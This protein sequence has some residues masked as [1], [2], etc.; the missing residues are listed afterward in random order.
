MKKI[1]L[2]FLVF[3]LSFPPSSMALTKVYCLGD[4]L[5]SGAGVDENDAYPAELQRM[6]DSET[7]NKVLFFN[8]GISGS[9]SAS[10]YSRL[11]YALKTKPDIIILALGANDGLRGQNLLAMKKSLEKAIRLAQKKHVTVLLAGMK[12]PINYGEKY[13]MTFEKTFFDLSKEFNLPIIPF[14]LLDVA[15]KSDLNQPDGIHPTPKGHKIIAKTV[16]QHLK[17]LIP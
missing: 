16:Y 12:L 13:R 7:P 2:L 14:L 3:L 8:G 9:T 15:G 4:S 5:T 6:F 11:K 10:A 1:Y 17:P